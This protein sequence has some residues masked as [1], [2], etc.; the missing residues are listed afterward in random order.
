MSKAARRVRP[1]RPYR[2]IPVRRLLM[3]CNRRIPKGGGRAFL[4]V[5]ALVERWPQVQSGIVY[6]GDDRMGELMRRCGRTAHRA[7]YDLVRTGLLRLHGAG[8]KCCPCSS[9]GGQA[10]GG[11]ILNARGAVVSAATGYELDPSFTGPRPDHRSRGEGGRGVLADAA[12]RSYESPAEARLRRE[13]QERLRA[14]VANL[15]GSARA[16]SAGP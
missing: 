4:L 2:R 10:A 8:P 6:C 1:D 16:G 12:A 13:G 7:K 14:A 9:C 11:K 5:A 3:E 15:K